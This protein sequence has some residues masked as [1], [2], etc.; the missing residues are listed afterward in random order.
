MRRLERIAPDRFLEATLRRRKRSR[1]ALPKRIEQTQKRG[2]ELLREAKG[3][4]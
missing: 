1:D 3:R 4:R 2:A